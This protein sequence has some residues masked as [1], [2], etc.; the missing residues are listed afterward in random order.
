MIAMNRALTLAVAIMSLSTTT[1][2]YPDNEYIA[3]AAIPQRDPSTSESIAISI[4]TKNTGT[5]QFEIWFCS[6]AEASRRNREFLIG[7][8]DGSLV[9]GAK[10]TATIQTI[11]DNLANI[12]FNIALQYR[13]YS[14]HPKATAQ[15]SLNNTPL[16]TGPLNDFSAAAPLCWQ[17]IKVV[18]RGESAPIPVIKSCRTK[19]GFSVIIT[20]TY[21]SQS[22]ELQT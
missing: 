10:N 22:R 1:L 4:N 9:H 7:F 20:F 18:S 8:D 12:N 19:I 13:S 3:T 17:S 15:V 16:A 11:P 14:L 5:N 21:P 6:D 2:A